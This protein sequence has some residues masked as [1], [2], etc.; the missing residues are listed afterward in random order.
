MTKYDWQAQSLN[1]PGR[2]ISRET[3]L[4]LAADI[5]HNTELCPLCQNEGADFFRKVYYKCSECGALFRPQRLLLSPEK[6]KA[7]YETHNNDVNDIRYQQFVSPIVNAILK[8]CTQQQRGLD[9][10]AG[11]GP[12]VSKLLRDQNYQISLYDPFFHNHPE[13]LQQKYDYIVCCEVIE[14]FYQPAKEFALLKNLLKAG[15]R[16]YCMTEIYQPQIDF[17]RWRYRNDETHVF[18]YQAETLE[19]IRQT[20]G[21]TALTI[22]NRLI[23]FN[24]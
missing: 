16:L 6:E 20:L 13:L 9:F 15:G 2:R 3:F 10:G 8:D 24:I 17:N 18:I 1:T 23:Q 21:F 5:K 7:R 11:T 14:H 12:V 22:D 19:W 4:K